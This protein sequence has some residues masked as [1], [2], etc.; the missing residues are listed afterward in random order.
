MAN[1]TPSKYQ[2]AVYDFVQNGSGNA[3]INAVAGS[4]KSTTLVNLL[5]LIPSDQKV[6]SLAFNK[7]AATNLKIKVGNIPNVEVRTLHSLGCSA[8]RKAFKSEINDRKY[9]D[10]VNNGLK[11]GSIVPQNENLT[12]AD[13]QEYKDNILDLINLMR[14]NLTTSAADGFELAKQHGI[15]LID[16]EPDM[17][18][19]AINWGKTEVSSIDFTDM[20]YLP[21]ALDLKMF[22]FDWVLIDECQDLNAAQRE[23]FLRV[24]KKGTGRFIAVGDP[25]Q[26]IYGFAGADIK[27]FNLLTQIPN[28]QVLPLSVCYRCDEEII[29]SAQSI[30][31]QIEWRE[32]A[33]KGEI[34]PKASIKEVQDGDMVLCRNS[35]PLVSLCMKYLASGVKAYVMGKDVGSNLV[36]ML[37][38]TKE[39]NILKAMEKIHKEG[40]RKLKKIMAKYQIIESEARED[41][42]YVAFTDKVQA[43]EILSEGLSLVSQL[44]AR[45]ESIFTDEERKGICLS[46]IHK[47]KGLE[48]DRVFIAC[49][50]KLYNKRAMRIPWMAVQEENLV[51]VAITR[52]KHYLGYI[53]DFEA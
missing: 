4:G 34:N 9:K 25:Q 5:S 50:E 11:Y 20:I 12:P 3:V 37:K 8:V 53:A 40:D 28:T 47:A 48:A 44:I 35:A 26:A 17:A 23:L 41:P 19:R 52:A 31:P 2:L 51:Y 38:S 16:N 1:F 46:T 32:G 6:L 15:E 30:V 45:I 18:I 10:W 33:D 43:I 14:V 36:N 22:R 13:L 27:S 7:S 21:V 39:T 42:S 29:R 24:V 49:P